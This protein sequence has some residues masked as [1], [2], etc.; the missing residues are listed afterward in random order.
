M[1]GID[2]RKFLRASQRI[3]RNLIKRDTTR[4]KLGR[5]WSQVKNRVTLCDDD[6]NLFNRD[7]RSFDMDDLLPSRGS[8]TDFDLRELAMHVC[9]NDRQKEIVD[10][11]REGLNQRQIAGELGIN[12]GTVSR[13][14][15]RIRGQ[16]S[17]Y[18]RGLEEGD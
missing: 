17:D 3:A 13:Y 15:A 5:E 16:C 18:L 9:E 10:L 2:W 12:E 7:G 14:L 4:R 6:G 8:P 11:L 1:P